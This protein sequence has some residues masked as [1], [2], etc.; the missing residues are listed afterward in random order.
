MVSLDN[1]SVCRSANMDR[2]CASNCIGKLLSSVKPPA[3]STAA[4]RARS[5]QSPPMVSA[6]VSSGRQRSCARS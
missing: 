6:M 5:G 1:R 4:R 2:I 3:S